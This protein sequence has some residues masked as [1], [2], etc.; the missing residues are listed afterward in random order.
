MPAVH[1]EEDDDGG[2]ESETRLG[3]GGGGGPDINIPICI[4]GTEPRTTRINGFEMPREFPSLFLCMP[5]GRMDYVRSPGTTPTAAPA[6]HR[7]GRP[8]TQRE[9]PKYLRM[10]FTN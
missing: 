1:A 6:R 2:D 3:G 8:A 7:T 5:V 4:L 9:T 10:H